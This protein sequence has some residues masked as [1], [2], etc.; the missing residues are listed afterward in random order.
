MNLFR[1]PWLHQPLQSRSRYGHGTGT[2]TGYRDR[3]VRSRNPR[4]R[5]S[6]GHDNARTAVGGFRPTRA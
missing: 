5:T 1:A 6:A 2:G 4:P 3:A